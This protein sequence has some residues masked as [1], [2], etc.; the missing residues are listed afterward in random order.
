LSGGARI[1]RVFHERF[2]FELIKMETDEKTLRREI[3]F[4][5]RNI[6]GVRVGLFTPDQAFEAVTRR[7]IEKLLAPCIKAADMVS[8]EIIDIINE[9]SKDMD[10]FPR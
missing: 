1:A 6:H 5:I 2:P 4:A 7:L 9:I 8:S 10:R 3:S